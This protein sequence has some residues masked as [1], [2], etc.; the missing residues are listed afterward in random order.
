MF[1]EPNQ[2][3]ATDSILYPLISFTIKTHCGEHRHAR[4][5]DMVTLSARFCFTLYTV[6]IRMTTTAA[7]T[8]VVVHI[9]VFNTVIAIQF[10]LGGFV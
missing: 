1:G 2:L 8:V 9:Q 4:A 3:P 7:A 6:F 10:P 5:C